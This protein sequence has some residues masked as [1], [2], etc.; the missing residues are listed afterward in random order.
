VI[1]SNGQKLAYISVF[2]GQNHSTP[3]GP[4]RAFLHC[5]PTNCERTTGHCVMS[6]WIFIIG[7]VLLYFEEEPVPL[8][9]LFPPRQQARALPLVRQRP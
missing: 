7:R 6:A 3:K 1:D 8:V 2:D 5:R 4:T 9:P